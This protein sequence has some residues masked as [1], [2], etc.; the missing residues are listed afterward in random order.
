MYSCI[1]SYMY[2]PDWK[3]NP[4]T[5]AWHQN[6]L[7]GEASHLE[8]FL[9]GPSLGFPLKMS[10]LSTVV[11]TWGLLISNGI[12]RLKFAQEPNDMLNLW[13]QKYYDVHLWAAL[14]IIAKIN[15]TVVIHMSSI[16]CMY[17][18][19]SEPPK[20]S[21]IDPLQIMGKSWFGGP[22]HSNL[23]TR[24]NFCLRYSGIISNDNSTSDTVS[25]QF[26]SFCPS[27]KRILTLELPSLTVAW[28]SKYGHVFQLRSVNFF[29]RG[30]STDFLWK[31][32]KK[33][34]FVGSLPCK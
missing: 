19:I 31:G 20:I 10:C 16:T 15:C 32:L 24:V 11:W 18:E 9:R 1:F 8:I 3:I 21:Q 23:D 29:K 26:S 6:E 33:N 13:I 7:Q 5:M 12:G 2:C 28:F 30:I 22:E 17:F 4:A 27:N 14:S 25:I 34:N